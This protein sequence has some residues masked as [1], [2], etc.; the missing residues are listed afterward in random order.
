MFGRCLV[1]VLR[2]GDGYPENDRVSMV[3]KKVGAAEMGLKGN[4]YRGAG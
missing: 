3:D 1:G 2:S 4:R